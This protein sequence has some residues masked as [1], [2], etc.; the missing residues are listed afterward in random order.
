MT[1]TLVVGAPGYIGTALSE[2]LAADGSKVRGLAHTPAAEAEILRRGHT[3][4]RAT[5]TDLDV[6]SREAAAADAVVWTVMSQN[7]AEYPGLETAITTINDALAGS[8]KPFLHMGAAMIYADSGEIPVGE[9]GPLDLTNPV[10]SQARRFEDLV[11]KGAERGVRSLA[12][13]SSLVYGRGGGMFVQAPIE[14]ARKA[15][16][17]CYVGSGAMRMSTVHIDDLVDLLA[18][19][20]ARGPAGTMFN[21]A[22]DPPVTTLEL[23]R[24]TATAAGIDKVSSIP[25]EKAYEVLGFMGRIMA[26]NAWLSADRAHR[27]LDWSTKQPSVL[28]ELT[29]GSYAPR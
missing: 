9:D 20:L 23:A 17:S 22:G 5:L 2:R 1:T 14:A 4:V 10:A 13:R 12:I 8:G 15:G 24:A 3:P 16:V 27:L 6:L 7:P 26:K 29:T 11:L 18:R 28:D 21:A 25:L 19:A